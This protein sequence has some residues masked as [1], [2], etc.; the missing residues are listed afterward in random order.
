[1][2]LEVLKL[3]LSAG[4]DLKAELVLTPQQGS[5]PILLNYSCV[6]D[7][8]KSK[9]IILE[10][11]PSRADVLQVAVDALHSSGYPFSGRKPAKP[12]TPDKP[13]KLPPPA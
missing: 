9:E 3:T 1:M 11:V 13:G 4:K 10:G 5:S 7:G 8:D 6:L 2:S 12:K